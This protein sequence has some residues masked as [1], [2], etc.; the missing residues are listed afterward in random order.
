MTFESHRATEANHR[1]ET[2]IAIGALVGVNAL[3]GLSFPIMKSLNMQMEHALG[4]YG[5]DVSNALRLTFSAGM[6]AIRFSLSMVVLSLCCPRL[7]WNASKAEWQ[8][9]VIVGLLFYVGLV[10][11]VMGLATIPAS[12]S[13][14]LTSLTAVFTPLFSSIMFRRFP[15]KN[16]M[17]GAAVALLGVALLTGFIV[18]EAG[19]IRIAQDAMSSWTIGDTWTT[20]GA[21]L[22]TGQ[23]LLVDYYGKRLNTAAITPGMFVVVAIAAGLTF[24]VLYEVSLPAEH[25]AQS[26]IDGRAATSIWL[27]LFLSPTFMGIVGF[28]AIFCSVFAFLGMNKYQPH[29]TAVQ[30]SVI[31]S[32]EPVFASM[33]ALFLPATMGWIEARYGY[34]NEVVSLPLYLGGALILVANIVALWPKRE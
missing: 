22:F 21:V 16:V 26:K 8:A 1:I 5:T 2:M 14:F 31:Y 18:I 15:A 27:D 34:P 25:T 33:W 23:L 24:L 9:G 17:V 3:W 28:L 11:Q 4:I 6:I 32:S 19:T 7:V 10:L 30:A 12:R 29:I 13:G 20:L